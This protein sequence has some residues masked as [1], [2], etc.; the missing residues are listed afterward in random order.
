MMQIYEKIF[1][2]FASQKE[3]FCDLLKNISENIINHLIFYQ[4]D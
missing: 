2:N 3:N 4:N 1:C